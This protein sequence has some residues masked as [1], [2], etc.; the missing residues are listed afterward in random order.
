MQGLD[1][2]SL[3]AIGLVAVAPLGGAQAQSAQ[4]TTFFVTSTGS[5]KGADLGGLDGADRHCQTLAEAAGIRGK[6]WRAYLSTQATGGATA[7]N[8]K[9]RIGRGP[10]QNAKGVVIAKDVADLHGAGN[11]LTKQ[12]ALTEKGEP[13]KGRGDQPNEHDMLTGSQPDGTA[14]AGSQDMTCGNWT[15]SGTEGAA[16]LGHHD[17]TGLDESPPA[18]SWNSSH[19]SRGG[20]SQDA[21]KGTGGA[22]LFYCFAAN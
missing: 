7:T 21:L 10:W 19:A 12:T 3:I 9:D 6:M 20:C 22:G 17:R 8:A 13:V 11:N 1:R 5:G 14:F 18:K 4:G 2:L 15:K 16:M